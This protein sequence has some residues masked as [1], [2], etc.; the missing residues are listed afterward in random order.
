MEG[1]SGEERGAGTG[2]KHALH[3]CRGRV[4][5]VWLRVCVV[6]FFSP[7]FGP[8]LCCCRGLAVFSSLSFF[9]LGAAV[10]DVGLCP[11]GASLRLAALLR[12]PGFGPTSSCFSSFSF[13]LSYLST[14]CHNLGTFARLDSLPFLFDGLGLAGCHLGMLLILECSRILNLSLFFHRM[15]LCT[16]IHTSMRLYAHNGI[17]IVKEKFLKTWVFVFSL[18]L[19]GFFAETSQIH[20][21]DITVLFLHIGLQN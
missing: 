7:V 2:N 19:A 8:P 10:L 5:P 17:E 21:A 16:N 12:W 18:S 20:S 15:R 3:S 1:G 11:W 9:P 13:S 14:P 4:V 6:F